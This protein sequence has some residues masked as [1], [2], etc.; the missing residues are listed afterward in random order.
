MKRNAARY[1]PVLVAALAAP[2]P[3]VAGDVP[4]D[5]KAIV[6]T[7][8]TLFQRYCADCHGADARGG[9]ADTMLETRR[10][11]DLT[12]IAARN[13]GNFP[14]WGLYDIISGSE[15]LPAHGRT[16]PVWGQALGQSPGTDEANSASVARGRILAIMAWLATIQ[17]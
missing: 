15:L 9:T 11:P 12:Q 6:N 17:E 4:R 8:N 2:L 3:S 1:L 7:G 5:D 16:M 14:F 13:D 10:T